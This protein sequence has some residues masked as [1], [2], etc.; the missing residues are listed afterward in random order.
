MENVIVNIQIK[1]QIQDLEGIQKLN[2]IIYT[3]FMNKQKRNTKLKRLLK[4]NYEI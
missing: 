3:R 1:Q 2:K 4:K